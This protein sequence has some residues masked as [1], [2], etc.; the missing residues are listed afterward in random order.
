[1]LVEVAV[2]LTVVETTDIVVV[3]VVAVTE[4]VEVKVVVANALVVVDIPY[5]V[6]VMAFITYTVLVAVV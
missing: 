4:T 5:A 3:V 2:V 1:V 6:C